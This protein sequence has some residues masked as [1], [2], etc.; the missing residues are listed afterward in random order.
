M[1]KYML[2]FDI[3]LESTYPRLILYQFD[4]SQDA[5]ISPRIGPGNIGLS[6]YSLFKLMDFV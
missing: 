5:D 1:M 3:T 4:V 6:Y 2:I